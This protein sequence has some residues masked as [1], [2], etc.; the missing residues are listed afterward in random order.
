M[1]SALRNQ[2]LA[3]FKPLA[4]TLSDHQKDLLSEALWQLGLECMP[5]RTNE[6]WAEQGQRGAEMSLFQYGAGIRSAALAITRGLLQKQLT[7]E[8]RMAKLPIPFGEDGPR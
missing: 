3:H 2:F 6:R 8:K 1:N 4:A 7:E 5:A